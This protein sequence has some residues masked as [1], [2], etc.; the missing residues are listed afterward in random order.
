MPARRALADLDDEVRAAAEA[1][2]C[3]LAD[4]EFVRESEQERF[5]GRALLV[6]EVGECTRRRH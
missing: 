5:R 3:R 1:L 2:L 6:V 4:D